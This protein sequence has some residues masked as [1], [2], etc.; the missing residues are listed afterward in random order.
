MMVAASVLT[1]NFGYGVFAQGNATALANGNTIA[2]NGS[3]GLGG[4]LGGV[5][6]TRSNNSGEQSPT[7]S[8]TVTAVPGF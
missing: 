7:T 5:V 8:G 1:E 6:N 4:G 3:G 2:G